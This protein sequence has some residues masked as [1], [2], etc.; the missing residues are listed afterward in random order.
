MADTI[1]ITYG[2]EKFRN[3]IK[4]CFCTVMKQAVT[5]QKKFVTV[6]NEIHNRTQ[7]NQ[8]RTHFKPTEHQTEKKRRELEIHNYIT[9]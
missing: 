1:K 4:N 3:R 7:K 5:V 2:Y 9:D 8:N 6:W